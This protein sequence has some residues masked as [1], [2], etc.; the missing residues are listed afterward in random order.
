MA[1][2]KGENCS[3]FPARWWRVFATLPQPRPTDSYGFWIDN[4]HQGL[5]LFAAAVIT[6]TI[7]VTVV[8]YIRD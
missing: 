6:T 7:T 5:A 4:V 2:D 1:G 8:V 3:V